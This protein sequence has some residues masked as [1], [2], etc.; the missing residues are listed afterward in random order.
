MPLLL[1]LGQTT[2]S[3][4]V[5]GTSQLNGFGSSGGLNVFSTITIGGSDQLLSF[6]A[7][8]GILV[9]EAVEEPQ[10][11]V[12]GGRKKRK[13]L[14]IPFYA[15]VIKHKSDTK[16]FDV[17]EQP[18]EISDTSFGLNQEISRF[19]RASDTLKGQLVLVESEIKLNKA[20]ESL[21]AQLR[22]EFLIEDTIRAGRFI[23][24]LLLQIIELRLL[25]RRREEEEI[26]ILLLMSDM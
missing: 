5:G 26:I 4:T 12:G 1:L 10:V 18:I 22:A 21:E 2:T 11:F 6:T 24:E 23:D 8:G 7:S 16:S 17:E 13:K 15:N 19:E 20:R 25:R 9:G 3:H 14:K